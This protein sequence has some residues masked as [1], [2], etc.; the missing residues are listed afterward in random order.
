MAK[1]KAAP[2]KE[3]EIEASSVRRSIMFYRIIPPNG[4]DGRPIDVHMPPI[5]QHIEG[6][7]WSE[8]GR[9]ENIGDGNLMWCK[10]DT[11][12]N[13]RSKI[14]VGAS[15][16]RAL[17]PVEEGGVFGELPIGNTAGLAE[18][19]HMVIFPGKT[20][21]IGAE[22]NLL[23]PRATRLARYLPSK[24]MGIC[25]NIR[26]EQLLNGDATEKLKRFA[27]VTEFTL[28]VRPS[29]AKFLKEADRNVSSMINAAQRGF[30]PEA[31]TITVGRK[32]YGR[33]AI[34][35]KEALAFLKRAAGREDLRSGVYEFEAYGIDTDGREIFVD[36]LRD[37][38]VT[39]RRIPL[40]VG[41]SRHIDA[42]EA[43]AAIEDAHE[44]LK[45]DIAG[46]VGVS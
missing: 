16:R 23:A 45:T 8:T 34:L 36:I 35:P 12:T 6:L 26:V 43:Y 20:P 32:P 2:T 28:Q 44:E 24:A 9:Y 31:V 29:Y 22:F 10:V 30:S 25:P 42:L 41:R 27:N 5:L 11:T 19:S 14:Q 3:D 39:H 46:A 1:K 21:V 38:L 37:R 33:R 18:I 40:D 4:E 13:V 17:P 15:R 7:P